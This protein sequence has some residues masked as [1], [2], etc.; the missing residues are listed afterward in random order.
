LTLQ[1]C[2]YSGN[3]KPC[4]FAYNGT[5]R[6][7]HESGLAGGRNGNACGRL[8]AAQIS[9]TIAEKYSDSGVAEYRLPNTD[10]RF[11]F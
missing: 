7:R 9:D 4:Q 5:A 11:S 8:P 3:K 1:G 10:G 6:W 2:V